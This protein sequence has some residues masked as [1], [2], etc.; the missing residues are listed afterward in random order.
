MPASSSA[1]FGFGSNCMP[2]GL[3]MRF[4]VV[5]AASAVTMGLVVAIALVPG[6]LLATISSPE[7]AVSFVSEPALERLQAIREQ[8]VRRRALQRALEQRVEVLAGEVEAL[9][10][11]RAQTS[12]AL[13]SERSEAA[14]IERRLDH[15]VPRILARNAAVRERREQVGRL[16]AD[17]ASSSRRVELDQTVRAR[18][19]AIS[20][21]MLRRL[22][23]AEARLATLERR[24]DPALAR[25]QEIE[26][27]APALAAEAQRLQRQREQTA[28]QRQAAL[29][30]ATAVTTEVAW[31]DA[32][33]QALS[34]RLLTNEAADRARAGPRAD[35]PALSGAAALAVVGGMVLDATVKGELWTRPRVG[36]AAAARQ[37]VAP[38]LVA[39][40][41]EA[42]HLPHSLAIARTALPPPPAKPLDVSR[43][44]DLVTAATTLGADPLVTALDV[45]FR[46]PAALANVGSR[47]AP[48]RLQRAQPP[49]L[50]V[51]DEVVNPF[52]DQAA[53]GAQRDIAIA[54]APGQAVAAPEAGR[55][56]FAG[57]FRSYGKLLIIEHHREYHTLLWGF[58]ELGVEKG[59]RVRTGQ[60][61]GVMADDAERSPAL[62]VEL[63][64]NGRPDNPLRGWPPVATR[65]EV[66]AKKCDQ[67]V[68]PRSFGRGGITGGGG[69]AAGRIL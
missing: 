42:R 26:R 8:L 1:I 30:R 17:L 65:S 63:R 67:P 15:L 19:L 54:A 57:A 62:H 34:Q 39:L 6:S 40:A 31:L 25:Q 64:R 51:P 12:A 61:V 18:L 33:Q 48:A 59:D 68:R 69:C 36:F 29:E 3:T 16:L 22:R 35:Q 46:E 10:M 38:Q 21:V 43:P 27:R 45:V 47:V 60:I 11:R 9:E 24:P 5:G 37:P 28:R 56:V 13:Q 50:P 20:P 66:D 55:V 32:E 44:G 23:N 14:M 41:P 52:S 4:R 58:S 49:L 53:A 2:R 7:T